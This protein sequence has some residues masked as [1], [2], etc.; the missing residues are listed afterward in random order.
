[1]SQ[2]FRNAPPKASAMIEALR[3]LGYST[4]A[5]IADIVDNSI[6]AQAGTVSIIFNWSGQQSSIAIL[7]DGIGM[8]DATLQRAMTLGDTSPLAT[9]RSDDL[10]RFG[11]GLKT[12][13]FS[14]CRS[15]TVASKQNNQVS[16]LRWDLDV[17]AQFDGGWRLLEGPSPDAETLLAPLWE[18]GQGTLVLWQK[19]DRIV[20]NGYSSNDF[21]QLI[22]LVEHHLGMVFHRYLSGSRPKLAILINGHRIRAWDPFLTNQAA[23]WFLPEERIATPAGDIYVQ[24]YVLPHRDRLDQETYDK[25]GG[26]QGW[27]AQQGFYV[28]RNERLLVAGSWLGL[29]DNDNYGRQWTKEEAY[30]LARIRLDIPNTAD[31]DWKIDI[32][33]SIAR[34]PVQLRYRLSGLGSHVRDRARRVF[35]YRGKGSGVQNPKPLESVWKAEP[36]ASGMRY[37][38]NREHSVVQSVLSVAAEHQPLMM[39]MLRLIEETV[40]V[41]RIWLDTSENHETPRN[42]FADEPPKEIRA[43]LEALFADMVGRGGMSPE[44]AREHLLRLDPFDQYPSLVEALGTQQEKEL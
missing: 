30:R 15:L 12:A 16:C 4:A 33:K 42:G 13:S 35:A 39:A 41:Q 32:R 25:G 8:D 6:S 44:L 24:G 3:G 7:D 5:A 22:D 14:Q 29:G 36:S 26:L 38:I 11:L 34:P 18:Q 2:G 10:G 27:T 23:T 19:L 40:P 43:V 17:L 28:Y 21:L 20:T 1:M 37:R 31:D 9:R